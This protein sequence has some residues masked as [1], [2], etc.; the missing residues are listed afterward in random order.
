MLQ[1]GTLLSTEPSSSPGHGTDLNDAAQGFVPAVSSQ[2]QV[3][4]AHPLRGPHN[5]GQQER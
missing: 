3:R 4:S 1:E 2:T 5:G